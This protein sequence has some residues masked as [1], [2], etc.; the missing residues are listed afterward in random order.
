MDVQVA[1]T[2]YSIH[3]LNTTLLTKWDSV[4]KGVKCRYRRAVVASTEV[5]APRHLPLIYRF[6]ILFF[7]RCSQGS[8]LRQR[9]KNRCFVASQSLHYKMTTDKPELTIQY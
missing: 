8:V 6:I 9:E 7:L 3:K 2:Q 1:A 4:W 5:V